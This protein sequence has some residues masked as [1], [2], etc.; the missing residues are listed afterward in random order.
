MKKILTGLLSYTIIACLICL[1]I[2]MFAFPMPV[3]NPRDIFAYRWNNGLLFVM[4][5]LPSIVG[6]GLLLGGSIYFGK[7][8][9]SPAKRFSPPIVDAFKIVIVLTVCLTFAI[10][11][12]HEVFVPVAEQKKVAF[13]EKPGLINEY[14][15]LAQE[16]LLKSIKKSEYSNLATFYAKKIIELD[17]KNEEAKDLIKRA[18][19]AGAIKSDSGKKDSRNEQLKVT[20]ESGLSNSIELVDSTEINKIHNASVLD[21]VNE[22][23]SLFYS[24]DYLGSHY[25][26]QM[27]I[28]IADTKDVNLS[29]ARELANRSW[30]ILS[31]AQVEPLTE[32]NKF[33]RRKVEGYTKLMAGDFLSSYYKYQTLANTKI[34]Y[35]RDADVQRY[36][37]IA[38]YELTQEY[39]FIDETTD[40]DTFESAENVY[41]SLHHDD[42]TYEVFYIKGITDINETGNMVRYLREVHIYFFDQYGDFV[43][44]MVVP[45]AKMLA[46][47]VETVSEEQKTALGIKSEW[48]TIPYLLLC[49]VDRDKEDVR[50][51]PIY[52]SDNGEKV[53]GVNQLLLSMP[54]DDFGIISQCTNGIHKMNF[55]NMQKMKRTADAYGYSNEIIMQTA[56]S[57][58]YYAFMIMFLLLFACVVAW[59]YRLHGER[60]FKFAWVFILP[61]V[62]LILYGL[63]GFCEFSMKLLNYILMGIAGIKF[64]LY[65]GLAYYIIAIVVMCVIFLARKGD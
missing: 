38:R 18:E 36:L 2:G 25:Y 30:N 59:N 35:A 17:P 60:L 12:V 27:A 34:N 54:Y 47:D 51:T 6:T 10:T 14:K 58:I 8:P 65:L 9:A 26:A 28:R 45:Y 43:K 5:I 15:T 41:F 21:L 33:F 7:I 4:T 37:N 11:I 3:L 39:F 16:Y 48:K 61:F 64:A 29:K 24:G 46:I 52:T 22:S 31:D 40:K 63:I 1:V 62:N 50:I 32:E 49:S 20:P 42:G 53:D 44:S 57:S 13:E 55:W 56:L 19:L 23:E